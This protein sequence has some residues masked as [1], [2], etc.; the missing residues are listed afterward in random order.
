MVLA[1]WCDGTT[2]ITAASF[3]YE[4]RLFLYK[5]MLDH[6]FYSLLLVS[7][8]IYGLNYKLNFGI[9]NS[10]IAAYCC[11]AKSIHPIPCTPMVQSFRG[12]THC[13]SVIFEWFIVYIINTWDQDFII[14]YLY[15]L[16]VR[17]SISECNQLYNIAEWHG[18][19]LKWWWKGNL[20]FPCKRHSSIFSPVQMKRG[21]TEWIA[22]IRMFVV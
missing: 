4:F 18:I 13:I 9:I 17:L 19:A 2:T 16:W 3:P 15:V 22:T 6:I 11:V 8:R 21:D 5:W 12:V 10:G 1:V 20:S 7:H 14:S